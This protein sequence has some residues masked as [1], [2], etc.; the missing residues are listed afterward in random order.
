MP[1]LRLA[2]FFTLG[3][4]AFIHFGHLF[5]SIERQV[6][7]FACLY[8]LVFWLKIKGREVL[9]GLLAYLL[10]FSLGAYVCKSKNQLP[11]PAHFAH[12]QGKIEAYIAVVDDELVQKPKS[13]STQLSVKCIRVNGAWTNAKGNVLAYFPP[14]SANAQ[15]NY[16]DWLLIAGAPA[17]TQSP[18]N[19]GEFD[20]KRFL[21]FRNIYHQHF[22]A[23]GKLDFLKNAPTSLIWEF[24]FRM[25]K[26]L[27]DQLRTSIGEGQEFVVASMLVLGIRQTIDPELFNAY[28]GAG[29]IHVLAVSGMHVALVFQL[30]QMLLSALAKN[31]IAVHFNY[32]FSLLAIWT[33]GLMTAF[34]PAVLRA[35]VMFSVIIL[36]KWI[37][38]KGNIYNTLG[39][40]AFAILLFDPYSLMSV[41]FQMSFMAVFGIVFFQP[42]LQS[43]FRPKTWLV[44]W[45]WKITCISVAAQITTFPLALLYFKQFPTY[46]L[47][48]NLWVIPI[49]TFVLYAGIAFFAVSFW[50]FAKMCLAWLLKTSVLWLNKSMVLVLQLPFS[51]YRT[52]AFDDWEILVFY[53]LLF[54]LILLFMRKDIRYLILT[55]LL[56]GS[57]SCSRVFKM[58]KAFNRNRL[59]VYAIRNEYCFAAIEGQKALIYANSE[60]L[61]NNSAVDFHIRNPLRAIGIQDFQFKTVPTNDFIWQWKGIKMG[62]LN[63]KKNSKNVDLMAKKVHYILIAKSNF[64]QTDFASFRN[65]KQVFLYSN[66]SSEKNTTVWNLKF[67]GAFVVDL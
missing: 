62:I 26:Q 49:S 6:I 20:Y 46:F 44:R 17:E 16:G 40:T 33:F 50:S 52:I 12:V 59:I 28:S 67:N 30:I 55:L 38:R 39:F 21:T 36:G 15:L 3:V 25:R 14:D 22:I 2:I 37:G 66:K 27:T 58:H 63:S 61:T 45:V 34:S 11:D 64:I 53:G 29:A 48:S 35:V 42:K 65:I 56:A 7:G 43:L 23:S 8:F 19:P 41:G 54:S 13:L 47:L 24:A 5:H 1:F 10:C 51:V 4:A 31:R 9:L 57:F 32:G 18:A 60:F